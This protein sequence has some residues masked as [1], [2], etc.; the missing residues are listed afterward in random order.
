MFL[1]SVTFKLYLC[2]CIYIYHIVNYQKFSHCL[3]T[4]TIR[5]GK[6]IFKC[7]FHEQ[8][9][10][11]YREK[12]VV[13]FVIENSVGSSEAFPTFPVNVSVRKDYFVFREDRF[14]YIKFRKR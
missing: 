13:R 8:F 1:F 9:C 5:I 14:R 4:C 2:I 12:Q 3:L 6:N 11:S 7:T 10:H